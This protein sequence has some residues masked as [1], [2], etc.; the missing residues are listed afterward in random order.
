LEALGI[1]KIHHSVE[2]ELTPVIK[3]MIEK[4]RHLVVI[5]EI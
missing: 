5:E 2:V 3:G 4:V 1:K